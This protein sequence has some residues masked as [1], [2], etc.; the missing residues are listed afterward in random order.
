MDIE[1]ILKNFN[2]V[3]DDLRIPIS[4]RVW[5]EHPE[6]EKP[7]WCEG[8]QIGDSKSNTPT[9]R[10]VVIY[11]GREGFLNFRKQGYNCL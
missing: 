7:Y 1:E 3:F 8:Y 11:T 10:N 6:G 5:Q 9:G 4:V 2:K